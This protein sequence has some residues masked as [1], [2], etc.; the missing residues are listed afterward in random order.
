MKAL[1]L[2]CVVG[3]VATCLGAEQFFL[4]DQAGAKSGPFE[5]APGAKVVLGSNTYTVAKAVA[6]PKQAIQDKMKSI[7]LPVVE[8]REASI[9]DVVPFLQEIS[10]NNDKTGSKPAG[11]ALVLNIEGVSGEGAIDKVPLV[12][13]SAKQVSLFDA[14]NSVCKQCRL[15]W[16]V[17]DASV[18]IEPMVK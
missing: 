11:V 8:L 17:K 9:A 4:V 16:F 10:A 2:A 15:Y 1:F 14:L 18:V 5:F 13:Y 7:I 12:T 6:T 3:A